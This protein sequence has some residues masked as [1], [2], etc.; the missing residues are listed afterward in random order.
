[1]TIS[2]QISCINK[3]DRP[4]PYERIKC[5]GGVLTNGK[6]WKETQERIIQL[7]D[8]KSHS[9]YVNVGGAAVWVVVAISPYGNKYIKTEADGEDRNN[10][11]NLPECPS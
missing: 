8:A 7:I 10:L 2:V 1:M 9:F 5:A 11:L 6:R 4:N 3:Q